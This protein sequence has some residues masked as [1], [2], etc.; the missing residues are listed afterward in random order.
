MDVKAAAQAT[1]DLISSSQ[2]EYDVE[3]KTLGH[4][5]WMLTGIMEGYIQ[6]D[7]AH[8]WL[9]YAQGVLVRA[10]VVTLSDVKRVNKE[11]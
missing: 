5:F 11:S 2:L 9:G 7:K 4:V 6:Y 8:R 3:G 10:G 1:R